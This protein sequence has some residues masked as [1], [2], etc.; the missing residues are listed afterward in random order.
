VLRRANSSWKNDTFD[1]AL[2]KYAV[3][4]AD[5][6]ERDHAALVKAI[7]PGRGTAQEDAA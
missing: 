3:S 2:A 4:Y 6:A 1:S 5:Q 7:R